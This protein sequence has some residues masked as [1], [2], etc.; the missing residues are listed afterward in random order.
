MNRRILAVSCVLGATLLGASTCSAMDGS[1][2]AYLR[3]SDSK[4]IQMSLD[5]ESD[6]N[7]GAPFD[8]ADFIGLPVAQL[9]SAQRIP[10]RFDLRREAGTISFD[11]TFRN[12][13][14]AGEFMFEANK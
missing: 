14:G 3:D 9:R 7:M 13:R 6:G 5:T 8:V 4:R 2:T 1:W 12:G 10:A 11:G